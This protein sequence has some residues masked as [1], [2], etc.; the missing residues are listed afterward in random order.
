M[1][2]TLSSLR[3]LWRFWYQWAL[4]LPGV[5]P[6]VMRTAATSKPTLFFLGARPEV[7]SEE[8]R[9]IYAEQFREPERAQASSLLYRHAVLRL[10]AK[11]REY[12]R[13]Y[14]DHRTL[15]LFPAEDAVQ[16]TIR[17]DGY[18]SNAPNME[19]EVV[20]EA[21]HFIVEER[22]ELVLDRARELFSPE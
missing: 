6:R 3:G 18:E 14:M 7:W 10:P 20:P 9:R 17:L 13:L 5:G 4:S 8:E 2:P 22:P 1:R 11:L 16:R 19:I 12:R 21:T 15:L